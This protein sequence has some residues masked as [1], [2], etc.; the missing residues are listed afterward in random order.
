MLSSSSEPFGLR[1]AIEAC[2]GPL[3]A[4]TV[5]S[6]LR[7]PYRQDTPANQR[8]G[9]WLR[10]EWDRIGIPKPLHL[11]GIHYALTVDE[12][13]NKAGTA[14]PEG[15]PLGDI[16]LN[17]DDFHDWLKDVLRSARWLH[18]IPF[19]W[20]NDEHNDNPVI[21]VWTPNEGK[22][23]RHVVQPHASSAVAALTNIYLPDADALRPRAE[24]S[25]FATDQPFHLQL[26]GEKSSLRTVLS[27]LAQKHE[28][29]LF[30][31]K[32]DMSDPLIY[33][34]AEAAAADGRPTH[35]L[36]FSDCDP[37]GWNMPI[38]LARKLSA[39]KEG[40]WFPALNI[41]VHRALL[42]PDQVRELGLP[43]T[44]LKAGESRADAWFRATGAYQTELDALTAKPALLK[45]LAV[46]AIEQFYDSTLYGRVYRAK[47]AW[48]AEAQAVLDEHDELAQA[49]EEA[50]TQLEAK[51][52]E[53]AE[54]ADEIEAITE[55]VVNRERV[56]LPPLPDI[57]QAVIGELPEPL[58]DSSWPLAEQTQRLIA[59]KKYE[60]IDGGYLEDGYVG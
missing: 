45:R 40:G 35:I 46:E 59:S 11:R 3:T 44:P 26:F 41:Q 27:P 7:D 25:G 39:L 30:L 21:Q 4:N 47:A 16:Y 8:I 28:A 56:S 49:R 43:S 12:V 19:E 22:P 2:P 6:T 17:N 37:S 50:V 55:A 1:A 13:D 32:G 57:P 9:K 10:Q 54:I 29:D 33:A 5:M 48:R 15:H 18:Y 51:R 34:C 58:C 31:A 52:A 60:D 53:L 14:M 24:V 38:V 23:F 20:V 36:Y 42:R